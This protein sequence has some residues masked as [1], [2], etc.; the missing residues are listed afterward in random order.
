[1]TD[2]LTLGIG[3]GGD[4]PHFL[5]LGLS[6]APSVVVVEP[7]VVSVDTG[8]STWDVYLPPPPVVVRRPVRVVGRVRTS[9]PA[10]V[11]EAVGAVVI[12]GALGTQGLAPEVSASLTVAGL[13]WS[14]SPGGQLIG[15]AIL[16]DPYAAARAEEEYWLPLL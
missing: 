6:S 7:P 9:A 8:M 13:I 15:E 14:Q 16:T 2:F 1:M 11:V 5:L 10:P 12:M 3:P 4:I